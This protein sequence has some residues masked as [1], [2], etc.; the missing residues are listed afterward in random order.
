MEAF[1]LPAMTFR[2]PP[3]PPA[4]APG[5]EP[6]PA[7]PAS[8][9]LVQAILAGHLGAP[10]HDHAIEA[11]AR[12]SRPR[13]ARSARAA[14]DEESHRD[15]QLEVVQEDWERA[16]EALMG[17]FDG[18]AEDWRTELAEQISDA[19]DD[20]DTEALAAL[21][22]AVAPLEDEVTDALSDLTDQA[23]ERMSDEAADQDVLVDPVGGDMAALAALA[24]AVAGLIATGYAV[25]AGREAVRITHPGAE[26]ATIARQVTGYLEGLVNVAARDLLGGSLTA[27]QNAGRIATL[28]AAPVAAYYANETLDKNTCGPC[29]EVDGKWLGNDLDSVEEVYPSG[30]YRACLGRE[31]CRGTVVAVW[32]PETT[33]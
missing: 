23:A 25:S 18:I 4:L 20:E 22:V 27:A 30:G 28:R 14:T 5:Q 15:D 33:P 29:R 17:T 26:G 31:R 11:R 1:E 10:A 7:L 24:A 8:S 32:R 9:A 19:V 16:L 21:T 3:A 6:F 12:E 2:D 13:R